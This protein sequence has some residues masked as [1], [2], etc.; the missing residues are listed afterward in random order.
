MSIL[1]AFGIEAWWSQ[2]IEHQAELALLSDLRADFTANND[3]LSEQLAFHQ[4]L[5]NSAESFLSEIRA[6]P[7][8]SQVAIP[9]SVLASVLPSPTYDPLTATLDAALASGDIELIASP[10]VRESLADWRRVTADLRASELAVRDVVHNRIVP[11]LSQQVRLA[12]GFENVVEWSVGDP[13]ARAALSGTQAVRITSQLEGAVALHL[14]NA[15]FVARDLAQLSG[16][17]HDI[18]DAIDAALGVSSR[19]SS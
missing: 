4:L 7:A 10:E 6:R 1:L 15:R 9:D 19:G 18:L 14:F 5:V 8:G 11:L 12:D 13:T 17:Q 2:R 16:L 3:R